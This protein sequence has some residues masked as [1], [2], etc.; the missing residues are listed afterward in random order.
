MGL[1]LDISPRTLEKV[2]YFAC[3]IVLDAGDTDLAYK[4]VLTE[5]EYREAYEKYGDTFR[6]GMGAETVKKNCFRPLILRQKQNPYR[7]NS[8][9]LQVRREPESLRDWKL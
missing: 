9:L 8:K 2:L 1:I 6:V 7:M 4:Q 3:Y 5:K